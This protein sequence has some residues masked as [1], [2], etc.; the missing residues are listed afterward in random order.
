[1]TAIAG[2]LNRRGLAFTADSA[3]TLTFPSGHKISNNANKLF[4]LSKF[5]PVG[6]ALYNHIDYMG[7]PWRKWSGKDYR[8]KVRCRGLNFFDESPKVVRSALE[9]MLNLFEE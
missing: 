2:I 6:V 5:H 1:M 4:T 7:V 9:L 8:V 3:A